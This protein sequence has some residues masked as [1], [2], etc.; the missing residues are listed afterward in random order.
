ML[1]MVDV[2]IATSGGRPA[3]L[4]E[5][6]AS[7]AAQDYRGV[8]ATTVVYDTP[9][10]P[11]TPVDTVS[12]GQRPVLWIRSTGHGL[13][14]ARN[15]GVAATT[16][17]W[18]AFL[19]DD[20]LWFP[21]KLTAQMAGATPDASLIGCGIEILDAHG[22]ITGRPAP[23]TVVTR[24]DLLADRIMELHP[25][26]FL[27]RRTA[28]DAI[29][30]VDESIPG[31]YGE[32]YDFLLR[33]A[34]LGPITCVERPLA[35]IR[36][37]GG[38]YFFSRW[39]TI[40][41]ALRHLLAAHPDFASVPHGEARILGQI[42]FAEAAMGQR[43]AALRTAAAAARRNPR[44]RRALLAAAVALRVVSAERVQAWLHQRG[45]GI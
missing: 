29:G 14:A 32:D 5:A 44:E 11:E 24:R 37:T 43:R 35:R 15:A 8:V 30:G 25:S 40:V 28:F 16:A 13:A 39:Q 45:R 41:A 34:S 33:M 36:W 10:D 20:D 21:E 3:L 1:P 42:A 17:A 18:V 23:K 26:T 6:V 27:L 2:V 31:G 9:G 38:S 4:A 22:A 12:A 19:D 7:V